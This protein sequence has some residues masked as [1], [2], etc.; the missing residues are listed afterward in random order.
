MDQKPKDTT[1]NL[2]I[3]RRKIQ[4]KVFGLG[5]VFDM[6]KITNFRKYMLEIINIFHFCSSKNKHI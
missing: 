4:K 2:S 5:I 6:T 1:K 3:P